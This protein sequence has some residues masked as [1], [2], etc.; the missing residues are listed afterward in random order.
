LPRSFYSLWENR[1]I[2]FDILDN[3]VFLDVVP[4]FL[5]LVETFVTI[6]S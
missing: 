2:R 1:M 6:A 5:L 4:P 3:P